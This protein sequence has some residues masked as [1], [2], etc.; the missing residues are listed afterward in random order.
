MMMTQVFPFINA[1][2]VSW[3]A[4]FFGLVGGVYAARR[5]AQS[6]S[7]R[8]LA[9]DRFELPSRLGARFTGTGR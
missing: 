4:H 2:V 1:S 5:L 8:I 3:E 6:R 7:E 9:L